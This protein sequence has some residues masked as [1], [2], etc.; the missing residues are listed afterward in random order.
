MDA[1][2]IATIRRAVAQ[3]PDGVT[4]HVRAV[5]GAARTAI[6]G[7]YGDDAVRIAVAAPPVDGAANTELLGFIAERCDVPVARVE[8]LSGV[9]SRS[10]LLLVGGVRRGGVLLALLRH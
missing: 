5:P 6:T 2:T 3:H 4:I 10:K 8:L 9:H 1:T 7:I